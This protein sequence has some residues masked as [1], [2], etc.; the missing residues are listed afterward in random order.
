M[1]ALGRLFALFVIVPLL[2]LMLLVRIGQ[3]VGLLPT[4]GLVL[5]TGAAGA[6]LARSEGLR[7]LYRFQSEVAEG[8]VPGQAALDGISVLIGGAFLLTPGILTDFV[9]FAL[10]LPATRRWIQRRVRKRL[11]QGLKSGSIRVVSFG[12]GGPFGT[13]SAN[14]GHGAAGGPF[15]PRGEGPAKPERLDPRH[16]IEVPPPER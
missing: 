4:V 3:A 10:L 5:L 1:T 14:R 16:E 12:T 8:R 6:W 2:E 13:G 9:G 11:E 15:D 7:V